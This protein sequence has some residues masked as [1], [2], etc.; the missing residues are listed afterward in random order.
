L[1][2]AGLL[3]RRRRPVVATTAGA[4]LRDAVD[5]LYAAGL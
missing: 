1:A 2:A 3:F 4:G 5:D